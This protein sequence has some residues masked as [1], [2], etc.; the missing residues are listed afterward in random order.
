MSSSS[1]PHDHRDPDP[2][3]HAH[4][5][6]HGAH[7]HHHDLRALG[8]RAL[9]IA[10]VLNGAFFVVESGVG[11]VTG[12]LALMSDA[13][14]MLTD[15]AA[16]CVAF[17]AASV[18]VR[19]AAGQA[20]YGY[21]R[22]AVLGGLGNASLS[23]LAAVVIVKE[24]IERFQ[25][26][27]AVPGLPVLATAAVGLAVNLVSAWWLHASG[28]KGV[29]M[30]GALLHM[31]GDALGSVAAIV[32]GLVLWQGGP[33]V[34]DAVASV[35]VAGVVGASAIPLLRDVTAILL[36]RAPRGV[37]RKKVEAL[38]EKRDEIAA[39]TGFH[40]W[41]LDDGE[42]VASF[43]LSTTEDDLHKLA[44][45]ADEVRAELARAL[46]IVHAT[47]EWRPVDHARDCCD[48]GAGSDGHDDGHDGHHH[49]DH[50]HQ[51][52]A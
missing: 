41:C 50:R 9:F 32:A 52:A 5:H 46:G 38:L 35:I 37:D 21:G 22:V 18:R 40:A 45:V 15:V 4:D 27:P 24:A 25:A 31:L 11:V 49:G 36:E 19:P 23:L 1:Q 6:D 8:R 33:V 17:A 3:G 30:R 13:V 29:N 43:V 51:P 7:G 20:T 12:S 2:H 26:P 16:L 39:V 14:H 34:V 48:D 44:H 10:L 42:T 47:I 28:D